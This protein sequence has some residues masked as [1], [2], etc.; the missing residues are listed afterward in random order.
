[1]TTGGGDDTP[2]EN[3]TKPHAADWESWRRNIAKPN[4]VASRG[5]S[6]PIA[7]VGGVAQ[8]ATKC[9]KI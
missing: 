4:L 7:V 9:N 3:L 1:M 8:D 6:L 5:A 2:S